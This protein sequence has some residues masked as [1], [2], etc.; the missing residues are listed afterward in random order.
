MAVVLSLEDTLKYEK[1]QVV[2]VNVL[3]M[4]ESDAK[5]RLITE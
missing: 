1:P 2:I 4:T 5:T 3:A